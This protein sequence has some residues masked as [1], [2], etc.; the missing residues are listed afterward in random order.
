MI[1]DIK[2]TSGDRCG[3]EAHW[4]ISRDVVGKKAE[5]DKNAYAVCLGHLA[6]FLGRILG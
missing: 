3:R 4:F 5:P 2:R 1:C 6:V